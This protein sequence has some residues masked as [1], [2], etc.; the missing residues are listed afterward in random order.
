MTTTATLL[1][2]MAVSA[3]T[4]CTTVQRLPVP[5]PSASR[6]QPPSPYLD[7]R[8][9]TRIVQAPAREALELIG[10]SKFPEPSALPSPRTTAPADSAPRSQPSSAHRE[11]GPRPAH[12]AHR[13]PDAGRPHADVPDVSEPVRREIRRDV[14]RNSDVCALGRKYGGWRADSQEATICAETYGR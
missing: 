8:R 1:V 5:E 6:S 3:L 12:P 2:T 10:P 11:R 14:P 9:Q 13:R 7:G 4:G